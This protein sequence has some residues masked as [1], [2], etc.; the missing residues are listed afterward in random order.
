M[1]DRSFHKPETQVTRSVAYEVSFSPAS[2]TTNNF[3][4][5]EIPAATAAA[6]V[7]GSYVKLDKVGGAGTGHYRLT[8]KDKFLGCIGA[9]ASLQTTATP[10]GTMKLAVKK[11]AQNADGTWSVDLYA[12]ALAGGAY[13][14]ADLATGDLVTVTMKMRNSSV[15][16]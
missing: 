4:E 2:T 5:G 9:T 1:A 11:P 16:P 13:A 3:V 6:S 10:D 15:K 12:F 8:T 14:A 7:S